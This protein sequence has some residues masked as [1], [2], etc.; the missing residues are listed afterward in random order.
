MCLLFVCCWHL[1]NAVRNIKLLYLSVAKYYVGEIFCLHH[2][3][4][5]YIVG[6]VLIFV[7]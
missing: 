3:V 4:V 2:A 1:Y 6:A 5:G 7:N